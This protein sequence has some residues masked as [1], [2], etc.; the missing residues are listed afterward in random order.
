[1]N[2]DF[3]IFETIAA[4]LDFFFSSWKILSFFI[5]IQTKSY[6]FT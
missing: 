1:V 4:K 3:W 6:N 2:Q 5:K